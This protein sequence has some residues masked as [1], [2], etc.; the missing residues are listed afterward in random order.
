MADIDEDELL[1]GIRKAWADHPQAV[2]FFG[3]EGLSAAMPA[4]TPREMEVL[5]LLLSG[6]TLKQAAAGGKVTVQSVWKHQQRIFHKFGVHNW[7]QLLHLI[8]GHSAHALCD[9]A[10]TTLPA[11]STTPATHTAASDGAGLRQ[12]L[13][14]D[15]E[16]LGFPLSADL[17]DAA[18]ARAEQDGLSHLGFLATIF[19]AL[20]A[21]SRQRPVRRQIPAAEFRADHDLAEIDGHTLDGQMLELLRQ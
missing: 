10:R 16:T 8:I 14:E 21:R 19:A 4:L 5:A 7:V 11:G 17:L 13:L 3:A 20:A 12:R 2:E 1:D 6:K 18:L 9:F 15:A